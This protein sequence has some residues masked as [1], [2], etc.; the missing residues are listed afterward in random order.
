MCFI[1]IIEY[2]MGS[3][4]F[5]VDS[6]DRISVFG[7][8]LIRPESVTSQWNQA[9]LIYRLSEVYHSIDSVMLLVHVYRHQNSGKTASTLNPVAYLNI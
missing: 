4:S 3:T 7:K 1:K 9:D 8:S 2:T 5:V 6:F